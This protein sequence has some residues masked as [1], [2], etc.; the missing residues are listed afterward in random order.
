V[1]RPRAADEFAMIRTRMEELRRERARPRAADDFP[2]IRARKEE[3]RRERAL[4]AYIW[5]LLDLVERD[6]VAGAVVELG[7]ARALVRGHRLGVFE[8]AAALEVGGDAGCPEYV[9]AEPFLNPALAVRRRI[10]RYAST[11]PSPSP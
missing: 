4:A 7:R 10:M 6:L 5:D 3:L 9:A 2:T 8:R 11:R 1:T